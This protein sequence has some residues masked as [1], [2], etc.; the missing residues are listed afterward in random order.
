MGTP[1][2]FAVSKTTYG[3]CGAKLRL[4]RRSVRYSIRTLAPG[5]SP[6]NPAAGRRRCRSPVRSSL[7]NPPPTLPGCAEWSA[8]LKIL[9]PDAGSGR[10]SGEPSGRQEAMQVARQV[11]AGEP[12]PH[13]ARL[14]RVER[15]SQDTRSGRWLRARVRRTQRQAGGDAGRP[16]GPRW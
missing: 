5:A 3:P 15:V 14:R 4:R 16:S 8:Y 10:E 12:A 6:A 13:A 1:T 2:S 11:L 7:V 9:D